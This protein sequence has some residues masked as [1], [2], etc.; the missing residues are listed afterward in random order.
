MLRLESIGKW[1]S[2]IDVDCLSFCVEQPSRVFITKTLEPRK[3]RSR[4]R[5]RTQEA[6]FGQST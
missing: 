3:A 1:M 2:Q 5:H 4:R 6:H